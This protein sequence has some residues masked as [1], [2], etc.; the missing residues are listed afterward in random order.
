[1]KIPFHAAV[2]I[3]SQHPCGLFALNKSAGL[4]SHPN[5]P[6]ACKQA[7][8]TVPYLEDEECYVWQ[9]EDSVT[10]R[11]WLL[12][13]LD[14]PTSGIV[15]G[16]TDFTVTQWV[17]QI[18]RDRK[19]QKTYLAIVRGFD[20][21]P[22]IGCWTDHLTKVK[23]DRGFVRARH[24]GHE[25]GKTAVT[26]F[27]YL[28]ADKRRLNLSLIELSPETGLTHQLRVQCAKHRYPIL[29]DKT[30]GDFTF[31]RNIKTQAGFNRLALH[32]SRIE[33]PLPDHGSFTASAPMPD[34]FKLL[35]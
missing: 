3:L 11:F 7:L 17:R 35:F 8:L 31:N 23:D 2:D 1:M 26:R 4:L 19:A 25:T 28:R 32:A 12:N 13:R 34:D 6:G 27:R 24:D 18:F 30:Y 10:H 22:K 33:I 9:D 21:H 5:L 14:S 15:I 16:S 29:G 20:F